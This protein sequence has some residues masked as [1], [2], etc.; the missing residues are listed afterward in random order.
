V[1]IKAVIFDLDGTL[2]N[3]PINYEAL[4]EKFRNIIGIQNIEPVT[5]TVAAL[6]ATLRG[7]VFEVWTAAEFAVLPKMTPVPEG[8]RLYQQYEDRVCGLV[9]MQSKKTVERILRTLNLSFH[10]IVTREDSLDRTVQIRMAIKKLRL[11]PESVIVIGDRE[12]DKTA[13]ANV[14][15]KFKMVKGNAS[16]V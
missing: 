7:K 11:K 9:T 12:T 15:C 2:V 5:E 3:L 4:Y 8:L 6:N 1:T 14:G 10:A 16:L 13:A